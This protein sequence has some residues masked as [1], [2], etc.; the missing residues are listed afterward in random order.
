MP[1]VATRA[2]TD[3]A[4]R[5]PSSDSGRVASTMPVTASAWC[6]STRNMRLFRGTAVELV[7][8]QSSNL[9]RLHLARG[10]LDHLHFGD[11]V[12]VRGAELPEAAGGHE[13]ARLQRRYRSIVGLHGLVEP[14][15]H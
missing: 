7:V 5:C 3:S 10:L 13:H 4:C 15:L 9:R 8:E 14:A 1:C 11:V 12:A 6:T 2:D